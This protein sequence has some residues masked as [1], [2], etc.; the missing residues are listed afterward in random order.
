MRRKS[1]RLQLGND[2]AYKPS[3]STWGVLSDRRVK[4]NIDPFTDGLNVVLKIKPVSFNYNGLGG[5][6][7]GE[8][9][10]GTVAQER[11]QLA[12]YMVSE[13]KSSYSCYFWNNN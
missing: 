2:N 7:K 6:P 10:I 4:E 9:A 8:R 11:Q 13:V 12:P 3:T 1:S 5:T